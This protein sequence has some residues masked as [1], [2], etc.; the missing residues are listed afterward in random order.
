M[1]QVGI[2][3]AASDDGLVNHKS[4]FAHK[5]TLSSSISS[6]NFELCSNCSREYLTPEMA[7][8][9]LTRTSFTWLQLPISQKQWRLKCLVPCWR[10][11][12]VIFLAEMFFL[13]YLLGFN[14]RSRCVALPKIQGTQTFGNVIGHLPTP[15]H[16]FYYYTLSVTT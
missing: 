14:P 10:V 7:L 4:A 12:T 6:P 11:V 1:L 3:S 16:I 5:V 8:P 9:L 2:P 15:Y 13:G